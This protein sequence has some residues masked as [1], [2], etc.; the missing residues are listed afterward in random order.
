MEGITVVWHVAAVTV[1]QAV[2]TVVPDAKPPAL[3]LMGVVL[4][5]PVTSEAHARRAPSLSHCCGYRHA[6]DV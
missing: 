5:T 6:A 4:L 1:A 3:A 2:V